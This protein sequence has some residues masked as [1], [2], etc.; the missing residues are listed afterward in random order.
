MQ[1]PAQ[2]LRDTDWTLTASPIMKDRLDMTWKRELR[3]P[4][5]VSN[6]DGETLCSS[7]REVGP[8]AALSMP[9]V[10]TLSQPADGAT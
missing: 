5:H 3:F 1:W 9:E 6:E 2:M 7:S 4:P 10:E 8:G